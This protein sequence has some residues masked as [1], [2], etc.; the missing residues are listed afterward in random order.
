MK[1]LFLSLSLVAFALGAQAQY[2]IPNS[3]FEGDFIQAYYKKIFLTTSIYYEP[4]GWHGYATIEG[5]LGSIGRS[6][7]KLISTTDV[8]STVLD[9][10]STSTKSAC[11]KATSVSGIVA[12]GVMTTGRIYANSMTATDGANNYNYSRIGNTNTENG[13]TNSKFYQT[14]T[15]HP[16]AMKVWVKFDAQT[17][18]QSSSYPYA[19]VSAYLHTNG[20][21]MYDPTDNVTNSSIIVAHASNTEIAN[22]GNWH[23]LNMPFVYN[24]T[25]DPAAILV[26]FTTNARPG[27][28][29]A[30]DALFIDDIEMVYNSELASVTYDGESIDF[31]HGTPV[32]NK[33]FDEE[34]L[35]LT[36][37]G[38]GASIDYSF[39]TETGI[40]SITVYGENISEDATNKH[41]YTIQFAQVTDYHKDNISDD[42]FVAVN[43]YAN[44]PQE[45]VPVSIE[46]FTYD[47][48]SYVN[49]LL[50]NFILIS[51]ENVIFVGNIEINN[52]KL[53]SDGE[54]D[55]FS[56]VGTKTLKAGS[57]TFMYQGMPVDMEEMGA[58]WVG[59]SLGALSMTLNGKIKD[60]MIYVTISISLVG[61]SV[62]VTYGYD[63]K[64]YTLSSEYGT[65]CIPTAA[66][67]PVGVKAYTC[68]GITG[69]VLNL[70]EVTALEA[71]TPYILEKTGSDAS[72]NILTTVKADNEVYTAG[73]LSGVLASIPAPVGSYVLQNNGKVGFYQVAAG[74]QPTVGANRCY[75][76]VPAGVKAAAFFFDED[77]ATGIK[78]ID[79][80]QQTTE[81]AAIYN[82]AGQRMS[83]MQKGINIINGKKILK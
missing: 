68:D 57:S 24:N 28:G 15:G 33:L 55:V 40:L 22:Y 44:D 27:A 17:A 66:A 48:S 29:V 2:Q 51:G 60:N 12:N 19:S 62:E 42:L 5:T 54:W 83:K 1:K 78:T 67:L 58:E 18:T 20:G 61:Q 47:G 70:V 4:E 71:Y 64:N 10:T 39:S 38:R 69:S 74:Q 26:T 31:S 25:N 63:F 37:N 41:D 79:N 77:D 9:P 35:S 30:D 65:I 43:G 3:T 34:K 52:L 45:N 75:L 50:E 49:F 76:T 73:Y 72:Y 81:G 23:Q 13:N 46:H 7:A 21:T 82:L 56:F 11:V 32:V 36:S 6:G 14:F 16:D 53:T 8:R 80:A 59:P